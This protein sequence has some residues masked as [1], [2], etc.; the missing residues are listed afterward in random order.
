MIQSA[1]RV[2]ANDASDNY[3]LQRSRLAY[4]EAAKMIHGDV[5]E[6]GTGTGYGI[7]II[8]PAA[9]TFTTVDKHSPEIDFNAYNNVRFINMTVPPLGALTSDS[10]DYVVMFQ[11]IEHIRHDVAMISEIHRVLRTGG[12]LIMT[13]PNSLMSLTRNP[14]HVREYTAEQFG[15]LIS[16]VFGNSEIMGVFGKENVMAYYEQNRQSVARIAKYDIFNMQRW[17]PRA[18]LKIPYDILNRIN[19]R[20]L[21]SANNS[22]T[23]GIRMDDYFI[24]PAADTCFDLFAVA[25]KR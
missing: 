21:L 3:V 4:H 7:E 14:W 16:S 6:I 15:C 8:S 12:K 25:E 9:R 18:L 17:M 10:F 22:L 5:L 11:V 2:S 13:T 23:T 24:A 1:E 19:R 20:K